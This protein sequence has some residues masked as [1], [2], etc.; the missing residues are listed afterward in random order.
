MNFYVG[1]SDDTSTQLDQEVLVNDEQA[2]HQQQQQ[3]QHQHQQELFKTV[4]T[5]RK[6]FLRVI[7][8]SK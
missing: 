6:S 4:R 1:P 8:I 2:Q 3:Q 5:F 7:G